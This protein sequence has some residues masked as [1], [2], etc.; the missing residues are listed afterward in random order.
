MLDLLAQTTQT[1]QAIPPTT[2]GIRWDWV[3]PW[4]FTGISTLTAVYVVI[5]NRFPLAKLKFQC[6][7]DEIHRH[8]RAFY[9]D[10]VSYGADIYDV[11]VW[12]KWRKDGKPGESQ[13]LVIEDLPNPFKLGQSR[14]FYLL[15][16]DPH[17]SSGVESAPKNDVWLV[18]MSG[19]REVR[20]IKGR[21]FRRVFDSWERTDKSL[22]RKPDPP[23]Q[24]QATFGGPRRW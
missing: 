12:F 10:V 4:T 16:D 8:R 9:V 1:T 21:K 2:G 13:L 11:S 5:R 3:V 15:N 14:R 18:V 17:S 7:H 6:K 20:V 24:E 19:V 22:P 23:P